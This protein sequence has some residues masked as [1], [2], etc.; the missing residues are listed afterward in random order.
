[1]KILCGA[2]T[3][4]GQMVM[5]A[6]LQNE[7]GAINLMLYALDEKSLGDESTH[8]SFKFHALDEHEIIPFDA[9]KHMVLLGDMDKDIGEFSMEDFSG[10]MRRGQR[11][12]TDKT[13]LKVKREL[14]Q[15]GVHLHPRY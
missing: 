14:K 3:Q 13:W 6:L 7:P 8:V 11:T 10:S 2:F 9:V 15:R 4:Q 5:G 1:M 12:I